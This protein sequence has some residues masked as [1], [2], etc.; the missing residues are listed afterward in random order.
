VHW[1]GGAA[2]PWWST[3][4][5]ATTMHWPAIIETIGGALEFTWKTT[6]LFLLQMQVRWTLP[7]L[8]LDQVMSLCY[9]YLVPFS[10]VS[11]LACALAG[12]MG[13]R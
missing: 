9:K 3:V 1:L 5:G 8:R 10:M 13:D 7:R 6:I 11:M 12:L 2:G 4:E